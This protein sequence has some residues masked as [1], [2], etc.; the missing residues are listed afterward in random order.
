MAQFDD[1]EILGRAYDAQ[2]MRRL[3]RFIL[4]YRGRVG[5][6]MVLLLGASLAELVGPLLIQQAI[7]GPIRAGNAAGVWPYFGLYMAALAA[8]FVLRYGQIWVMQTIG[9]KIM[10]DMRTLIFSHIQR[11]S[12]AFFD[13]NPV[14]RL[15]TRLTGDV[16]TL[17]EFFTQGLV[18]LVGN[19]TT[20][21]GVLVLMFVLNWRLAI[22]SILVL[23]IVIATTWGFQRVMRQAYRL[24][25]Q[26][27]ARINA[28]LNEQL[29]GVLVVQ[30]F[31]GERRSKGRFDELNRDYRAANLQTLRA[32][33]LFFPTVGF[34]SVL[35]TAL[36][37]YWGGRGSTLR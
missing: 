21:I 5:V 19:F 27:I 14:G 1:D 20:L 23:P 34:I 11:M 2:L 32:F 8:A 10:V 16:D 26:R 3:V 9:Q 7:D 31:N 25:R 17:N 18:A 36:L 33:A 6:A 37:L 4:P 29:T 12:L 28:F 24:V 30:L 15:I 13:R 35:G 22:L